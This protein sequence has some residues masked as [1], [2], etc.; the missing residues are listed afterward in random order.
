MKKIV[1]LVLMNALVVAG[2]EAQITNV[3]I[4]GSYKNVFMLSPAS[5]DYQI[6]GSPY[7]SENWL[8]GTLELTG[9]VA[10]KT[11]NALEGDVELIKHAEMID[12]CNELIL[13]LS[14]P[15]YHAVELN[16]INRASYGA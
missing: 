12:K 11:R 10:D 16:L 7:L 8:Y 13:K 15:R 1:F 2:S 14:D 6:A 9:E 4:A 3:H 5:K